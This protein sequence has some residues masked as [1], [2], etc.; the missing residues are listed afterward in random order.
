MKLKYFS[1]SSFQITTDS[2]QVLLID[3]F[4]D[5]PLASPVS[6]DDFIA[7][8]IILTINQ[9]TIYHT[10]DTDL[11]YDMKL[12][13]EMNTVDYLLLLIGDNFTMGI[14]NAVIAM[15][16]AHSITAIP[17]QYNNFPLKKGDST[18][19]ANLL[20]LTHIELIDAKIIVKKTRQPNTAAILT[21]GKK[22]QQSEVNH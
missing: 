18:E 10:N 12:I 20:R 5:A 1:H 13:G 3:P 21:A 2:G 19:F 7:D 17:T 16:L 14:D 11:F 6:S 22:T 15:E 9:K 4:L 8:Y